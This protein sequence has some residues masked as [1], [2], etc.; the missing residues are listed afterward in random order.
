MRDLITEKNNQSPIHVGEING[1]P[2][3][4]F[5]PQTDDAQM[6]WVSAADLQH[7]MD[8]PRD[9]RRAMV[10]HINQK[11]PA[12]ASR[13]LTTDGYLDLWGFQAVQGFIPAMI[14]VGVVD[15]A[16]HIAFV[17]QVFTAAETIFPIFDTGP[18][19]ERVASANVVAALLGQSR[20]AV[21]TQAAALGAIKGTPDGT[22][23]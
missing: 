19:G 14:D 17:K 18:N 23:H 4:F 1:K 21:N 7:A 16:F 6:P 3:R 8:S 9:L 13:V 2:L 20:E 12:V 15:Q 10:A 22:N 11:F 5:R